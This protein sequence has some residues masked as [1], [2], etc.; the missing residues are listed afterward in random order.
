MLAA[1]AADPDVGPAARTYLEAVR[2]RSI[3]YDVGEPSAGEL[4]AMLVGAIRAAVAHRKSRPDDD[5][6]GALTSIRARVPA[7][8]L[9]EFDDRLH[10]ARLANRLRDERATYSDGWAVGLAR[11]A[12]LEA[13]RRLAA[14][15]RLA[16]P[17]HAVDADAAELAALLRGRAGPERGGGGRTLSATDVPDRRRRPAAA[18]TASG[19][20]A[21]ARSAS[22]ARPTRHPRRERLDGELFGVPD[23]PNAATVV[24]GLAVNT[25]VYEGPARLVADST[26]FDRVQQR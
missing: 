9:A 25:G 12:L 11:R 24:H 2:Y 23:T 22:G 26:D 10:E 7:E 20:A 3:G 6:D 13:G 4:P 19:A 1:L 8:H 18:R 17:A 14:R 21:A 15:G 5:G 16:D